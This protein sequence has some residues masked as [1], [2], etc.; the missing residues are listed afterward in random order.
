[1]SEPYDDLTGLEDM[2]KIELEG[3]DES[4]RE[5]LILEASKT[6][7]WNEVFIPDLNNAI[8]VLDNSMT[9]ELDPWKRYGY[10]EAYKWLSEFKLLYLEVLEQAQAT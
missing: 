8:A 9:T 3:N 2:N 5:R 10:V 1:M 7:F 4:Y 6:P